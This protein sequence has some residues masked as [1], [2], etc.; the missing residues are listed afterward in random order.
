MTASRRPASDEDPQDR[1]P[2]AGFGLPAA[3]P[4]S[5][6]TTGA[7]VAA[8][9]IDIFGS[10]GVA[11]L[12]PRE[13]LLGSYTSLG[14]WA[15]MTVLTVGLVGMTPGHAIL[16]LRV[17]RI[18]RSAL[19]GAWAVPRTVLVFLVVPPLVVDGDGRGLHD[20]LCRTVVVR[21]R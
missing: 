10:A 2:G 17:A 4:G 18:D 9:L 3:G 12:L 11:L 8:F 1:H 15:L 16:G 6:A 7:R 14:V 20:R 13:Q 19:V 5:V 21:T